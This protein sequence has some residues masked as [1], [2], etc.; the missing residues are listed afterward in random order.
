MKP[1]AH[2]TLRNYRI[3]TGQLASTDGCGN[4]GAFFL[5]IHSAGSRI[6]LLEA[7]GKHTDI[8][9][10]I[11]SDEG[12]WDHVSVSL[13]KR[14]PSWAEMCFVK[15]LIFEPEETVMQLHPPK[16]TYVNHHDHCL[17][18]WR[19]HNRSIPMPPIIMV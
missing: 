15:D 14:T 9:A 6:R 8:L 16:S 17:H 18:L 4:S 10:V 7:C 1:D 3:R 5:P 2:R 11:M 19:P 12:G 13:Q